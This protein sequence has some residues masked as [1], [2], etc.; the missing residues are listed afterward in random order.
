MKYTNP[1]SLYI[2]K[3]EEDMAAKQEPK[4]IITELS[5]DTPDFTNMPELKA[6]AGP[7]QQQLDKAMEYRKTITDR[8]K[9]ELLEIDA[10][11]AKI[12]NVLR[13]LGEEVPSYVPGKKTQK[14]N[15]SG[16][17]MA[18]MILV[19][20]A[21]GTPTGYGISLEAAVEAAEVIKKISESNEFFTQK[22]AYR[23]MD[24]DQSKGSAC[25]RFFESIGF[26]KPTNR[27]TPN[28]RAV[29]YKID[30]F[31]AIDRV[32]AESERITTEFRKAH[33]GKGKVPA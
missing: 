14:P 19:Q 2:R 22:E 5:S 33:P 18:S 11:I 15:I 20:R 6:Y 1:I 26:L 9:Q 10:Q 27:V 12:G 8:H 28:G 4:N 25:F 23:E 21:S 31:D 32:L 30:D 16:R 29:M 7:L 24:W 3:I 17:K 13:A